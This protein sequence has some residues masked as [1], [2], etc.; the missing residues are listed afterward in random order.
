[1]K[2]KIKLSGADNDKFIELDTKFCKI[3]VEYEEELA[4]DIT[5]VTKIMG[6]N[7][8]DKHIRAFAEC[9]N[10]SYKNLREK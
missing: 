3:D 1:M 2:V 10:E 7:L 9:W 5:R 8:R 6:L 4:D